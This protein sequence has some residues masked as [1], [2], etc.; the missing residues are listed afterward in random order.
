MSSEH[1]STRTDAFDALLEQ[2]STDRYTY[3]DPMSGV[4]PSFVFDFTAY[5][6]LDEGQRWSTWMSVEPLQRGPE[7]RPDWVVTSQG[8][9][10]TELGILKTGKEADVV[11]VERA[12]P[13]HPGNG[14]VMAAK[15]Y[16]PPEHRSFHRSASYMEGR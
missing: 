7:P 14:V 11:L 2:S 8:A 5:D 4:D 13:L 12:D 10:D 3:V 16:R 9:I 6:D 15:R 1:N